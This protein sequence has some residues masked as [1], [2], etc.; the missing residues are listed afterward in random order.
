ML[1]VKISLEML[2]KTSV[3]SNVSEAQTFL[4]KKLLVDFRERNSKY[5]QYWLK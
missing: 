2:M 1:S 3:E 5:F 4:V